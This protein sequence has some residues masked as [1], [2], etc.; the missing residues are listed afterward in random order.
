MRFTRHL[1]LL[2]SLRNS[3]ASL[4]CMTRGEAPIA[5]FPLFLNACPTPRHSLLTPIRVM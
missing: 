4:S 5:R 1:S 2:S 3:I